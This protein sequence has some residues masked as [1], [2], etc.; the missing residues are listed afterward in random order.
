MAGPLTF[1]ILFAV[2]TGLCLFEIY[3]LADTPG[4]KTQKITGIVAGII[5]FTLNF[6]LAADFISTPWLLI[7]LPFLF[8]ALIRELYLKE[9][10]PYRSIAFTLAGW[11]YP[12]LFLSTACWIA[13]L[14]IPE[15]GY[16][17]HMVLGLF[18]LIW[19]NDTFAYITGRKLGRNKLFSR[20]SPKKTWEGYAGGFLFTI[21]AAM[22][23][24]FLFKLLTLLNWI[25][26]SMIVSAAG[27]YGDLF[28]SAIKRSAGTKESGNLIPGH[29]GALDRFDSAIFVFPLAY[30]FLKL[31]A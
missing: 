7:I 6:L 19:T 17:H 20:I 11:I 2:I 15:S 1:Y 8:L 26:L 13:Y 16:S 14:E 25:I 10:N 22:I 27:T 9:S 3:E 31:A 4:A 24:F 23:I 30:A 21:L 12:V 5:I 29:G 18:V 28:E